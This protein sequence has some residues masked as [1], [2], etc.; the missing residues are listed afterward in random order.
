MRN[1][2][3]PA[4]WDK[5]ALWPR[6]DEVGQWGGWMDSSG[7]GVGGRRCPTALEDRDERDGVDKIWVKGRDERDADNAS[8]N[9]DEETEG[10]R[11]VVVEA[12]YTAWYYK[13]F[14][15]MGYKSAEVTV[16]N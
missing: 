12:A 9:I 6:W 13:W 4:I 8:W 2:H 11:R 1:P 7:G 15:L 14:V 5:A 10:R 16:Q 3:P